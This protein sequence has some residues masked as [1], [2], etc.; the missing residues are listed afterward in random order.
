MP[1][2]LVFYSERETLETLKNTNAIMKEDDHIL[3]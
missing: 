2:E 1:D 3:S